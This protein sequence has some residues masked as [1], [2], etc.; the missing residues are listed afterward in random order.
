[1]KQLW[2]LDVLI[3][4]FW[5][6]SYTW[7]IIWR[8]DRTIYSDLYAFNLSLSTVQKQQLQ[9]L[10]SHLTNIVSYPHSSYLFI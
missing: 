3:V 7:D 5:F 1:M 4:S 9:K 10:R 2:Q 8:I 6:N